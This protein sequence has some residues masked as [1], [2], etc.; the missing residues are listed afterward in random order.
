MITDDIRPEWLPVIT[1]IKQQCSQNRG[2]A[3]IELGIPV[4]DANP[5]PLNGRT[6]G[7]DREPGL[8]WLSIIRHLQATCSKNQGLSVVNMTCVVV[9]DAPVLWEEA[10]LVPLGISVGV[11]RIRPMRVQGL[12]KAPDLMAAIACFL[13]DVLDAT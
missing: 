11:N 6:P 7:L 13:P 2:F 1:Y 12:K 10:K 4:L 8:G 5:L 3:A 9:A